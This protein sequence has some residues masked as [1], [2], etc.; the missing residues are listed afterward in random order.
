MTLG[1]AFVLLVILALITTP[2]ATS[3]FA[4]STHAHIREVVEPLDEMEREIATLVWR[5]ESGA[6]RY[7]IT[8]NPD[9]LAA[10]EQAA[11]EARGL[12]PDLRMLAERLGPEVVRPVD[13]MEDALRRWQQFAEQVMQ[14]RQE[15][16]VAE[17]QAAVSTETG[18]Q[19]LGD[20]R[21]Q[22]GT[23]HE[24]IVATRES[25]RERIDRILTAQVYLGIVLGGLGIGAALIVAGLARR[26]ARLEQQREEFISIVAH[27]LKAVVTIIR[28]YSDLLLRPE[29][30]KAFPPVAQ[31]AVETMGKATHRLDRMIDD[32]L[33]VSRIEARRLRLEK[34]PVDLVSLVREVV[35][36]TG[37]LTRGHPANVQVKGAVPLIDADP[38]RIEQILDNLLTNAAKYSYP[39][40]PITVEVEPRA[41]EVIVSVTNEGPGIEPEDIPRLFTR[42]YRAEAARLQEIP[43]LGLGLY[44][45]KGLVEAHGGRIW[46]E[47]ERGRYTTF[48]FTL[49]T[50]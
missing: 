43:G 4:I 1:T 16:R 25:D 39:S 8:G 26:I 29:H 5:M 14:L 22:E 6:L 17:A 50:K 24:T 46:V 40:T 7:V 3:W 42:F 13:E 35:D 38:D 49:P 18:A 32:L 12:L 10:Y 41:E 48:H 21:Q 30:V 31:K 23:L 44:I 45:T 11:Q 36:R 34:K 37:E 33:D 28:G 2:I 27:D 15:G 20:F 47:S 19:L 9:H